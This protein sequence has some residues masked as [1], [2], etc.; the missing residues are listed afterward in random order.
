MDDILSW[1]LEVVRFAQRPAGPGL[2]LVMKAVTLLGTQWFFLIALP[3]V[4]WCV[5]KRRGARLGIVVFAS[6]FV[7]SWLKVVF[8]QP[9]PYQLDP[10]LGLASEPT[11]GLPSGHAQN[12]AAFWGSA[13]PLFRKPW[14]LALA[15]VLPLLI[16]W[17]RL[18]L[19]VHFPTDLFLGWALGALVAIAD[20]ALGDN[21]GRA[22]SKLRPQLQL[23]AAAMVALA[24]NAIFK[25]DT[26]FAGCFF[27]LAAG[28]VY[29]PR[30]A[31]F[32]VRGSVGTRILRYLVGIATVVAVYLVPKL[33]LGD[34]GSAPLPRFL[35]YAVLGA[36]TSLGAPWL[37]LTL[38]LAER[39]PIQSPN[40]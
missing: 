36:W 27:G 9:R 7:N 28:L 33:L 16:G 13:A 25:E 10:K 21:I 11:F 4:Y 12:T 23:A 31:P 40:A 26:T 5:D 8:A 19:G 17:T 1:G 18:Y 30:A 22:F 37:F 6:A 24:M 14:G 35:R 15:L 34:A 32:S 39:E 2:T 3:L 20:L 29:M 38:R